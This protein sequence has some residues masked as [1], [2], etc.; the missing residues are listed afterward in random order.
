MYVRALTVT[1]RSDCLSEKRKDSKGRI[2]RTGESQRPDGMYQYRYRDIDGT[3]RCVY[4][5]DLHNLRKKAAEI[6]KNLTQGI[7]YMDGCAPLSE[8]V[9]QLFNLKRTWCESTRETMTRY[10]GILKVSKIYSMPINRI[11]MS[12]CKSY[13]ISLH[14]AKYAYGT[15]AT[16]FTIMKMSFRLA[17][18]DNAIIRDP[19]NFPLS[20][21]IKDD[22]PKVEA[23]TREQEESLFS[24]LRSD[25]VG[26]KHLD[27][28]TVLIG[29]GLRIS[30]F[31]ALTLSDIDFHAN[32]IH[33]N[34]QIIRLVG[35][36]IITPPKSSH[37]IRDIPMTRTVR[38]SICRMISARQKNKKDQMIDGYVGFLSV[39]RNGRPR[40]H[41]EYADSMRKLIQRYN[42]ISD[43]PIE[44]CTP[45]VLR[46]TF[47]TRCIAADM[48]VK[49][50][51][52]LMGH[53]D[54]ST[55]L[56]VYADTVFEKV[57][58]N[59]ELLE[60]GCN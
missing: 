12:D 54:A 31:A 39:T 47:C 50:V 57:V 53:S 3:R 56:N 25:A 26:K 10:W 41:S 23:L 18:E 29:T 55:T 37:A 51:Q 35:Q 2:L 7:S 45:H 40:T 17:C 22:T 15:I 28:I 42:E 48:D 14:D 8:V 11:K 27:M 32:V 16:V 49:T 60:S 19:T 58:D 9:E 44:R 1:E 59:M 33:V 52:Y 46:H 21:I 6:E 38:E 24:F 43:V 36:V 30:E 20:D 13:L 34:K 4:D 5:R